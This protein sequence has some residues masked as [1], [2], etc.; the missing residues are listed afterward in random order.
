VVGNGKADR[1]IVVRRGGDFRA[2]RCDGYDRRASRCKGQIVLMP[3]KYQRL[4][5]Y[6]ETGGK[7]RDPAH[8]ALARRKIPQAA[9]EFHVPASPSGDMGCISSF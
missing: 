3:G 8:S 1:A 2:S 5:D 7:R 4:E 6:A 9:F